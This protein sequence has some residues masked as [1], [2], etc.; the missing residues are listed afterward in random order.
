MTAIAID[1]SI[2]GNTQ[3][4]SQEGAAIEI[5]L[6][7]FVFNPKSTNHKNAAFLIFLSSLATG[8]CHICRIFSKINFLETIFQEYHQCVKHFGSRSGLTFCQA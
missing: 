8:F 3:D 7:I 2:F 5:I 4:R 1:I 6:L